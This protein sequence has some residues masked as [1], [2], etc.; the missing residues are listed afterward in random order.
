MR[1]YFFW[2]SILGLV[3]V[4]GCKKVPEGG[5]RGVIKMENSA[6]RY[7]DDIQKGEISTAVVD[8]VGGRGQQF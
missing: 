4:V 5:N 2:G 1:K 3:F 7:D 6:K 8:T